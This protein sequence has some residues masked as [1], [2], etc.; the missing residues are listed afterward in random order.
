MY[1]ATWSDVDWDIL[2]DY[3]ARYRGRIPDDEQTRITTFGQFLQALW[4]HARKTH[5]G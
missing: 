2:E 1:D 5:T 3:A 4:F